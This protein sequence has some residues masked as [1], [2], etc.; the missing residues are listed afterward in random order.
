M[1]ITR[2]FRS[3]HPYYLSIERVF[4]QWR[5]IPILKLTVQDISLKDG[6]F[7]PLAIL[8]NLWQART[9]KTDIF[10]ITGDVHYLML[11]LPSN[12]TLL[13]IHDC[14]FLHSTKGLKRWIL[15][16]LYLDW[17]VRKARL[18]STIS[19][20]SK[21]EII[22][23][24]HCLPEK[25][26]VIPNPVDQHIYHIPKHILSQQPKLL[27]I[28]ATPNK[29][30]QRLLEALKGLNCSLLLIG[31]YSQEQQNWVRESG[32]SYTIQSG[33]TD[34]QMA[35]AYAACDIVVFPSLYEG[36]GL[37]VIEGQKAGRAVLTSRIE[38]MLSV[39]GGA[40]H[41][42]DPYSVVSIREG[43]EKLMH[44]DAYRNVLIEKGLQNVQAYSAAAI[45]QRYG[46]AYFQLANL[47]KRNLCAE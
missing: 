43:I 33:L 29:N 8:R 41:L 47:E 7:N 34:A 24:T 3:P 36:F 11:A 6:L 1:L 13:T 20:K 26:I 21:Q 22:Q 35:D 17:P 25:I 38:P 46:N 16:K 14:V 5:D 28:G 23:Y 9:I 39:C 19:E 44:D 27:F 15:K 42:V 31:S 2:I 30:L 37:P 40:A 4:S 10:H 32:V 18:I 12:R 45:A